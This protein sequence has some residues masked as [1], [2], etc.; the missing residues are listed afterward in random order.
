MIITMETDSTNLQDIESLL[1]Q[2]RKYT[3][4]PSASSSK[5]DV[6]AAGSEAGPAHPAPSNPPAE[7]QTGS[8][9]AETYQGGAP[10]LR[11]LARPESA[12][13]LDRSRC[14]SVPRAHGAGNGRRAN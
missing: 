7:Y 9:T 12:G 8:A 10:G 3:V 2:I 14:N 5:G 4:A 1:K 13:N 11:S 6:A